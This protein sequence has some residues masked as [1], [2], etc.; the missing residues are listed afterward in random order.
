MLLFVS[1]HLKHG[2]QFDYWNQS[3][4]MPM[5]VCYLNNHT[6]GLCCHL[7]T[8]IKNLVHPLQQFYFH[9]WLIYWLFFVIYWQCYVTIDVFI[10]PTTPDWLRKFVRPSSPA[11][12]KLKETVSSSETLASISYSILI[13]ECG[14]TYQN[15]RCYNPKGRNNTPWVPEESEF[16]VNFNSHNALL[17]LPPPL[18]VIFLEQ[19]I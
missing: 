16:Y 12:Y 14:T 7:V 17:Y 4:N 18:S 5:P 13:W 19:M 9:L 10:E 15:T 8:H 11:S 2:R 1:I 3:L 6:A